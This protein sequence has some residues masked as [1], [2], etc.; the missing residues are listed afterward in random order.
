MNV[1]T[2]SEIISRLGYLLR[3]EFGK[4]NLSVSL[5]DSGWGIG[6]F[7]SIGSFKRLV[8]RLSRPD[9]SF[10]AEAEYPCDRIISTL[11]VLLVNRDWSIL[12]PEKKNLAIQ[13]LKKHSRK[14]F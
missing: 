1:Y 9:G 6:D 7:I 3:E 5:Y 11:M 12:E 10:G 4:S 2:R 13:S 8:E 14:N